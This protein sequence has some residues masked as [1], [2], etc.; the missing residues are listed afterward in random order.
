LS[1]SHSNDG[2]DHAG[3]RTAWRCL[4]AQGGCG[5]LVGYR[6]IKA[7]HMLFEPLPGVLVAWAESATCVRC[8]N[9]D[10]R[11]LVRVRRQALA[12]HYEMLQKLLT[13]EPE[14]WYDTASSRCTACNIS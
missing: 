7:G 1:D 9:P 8:P 6:I 3:K 12:G 2:K 13:N 14:L 4:V 5:W 11:R 10:C